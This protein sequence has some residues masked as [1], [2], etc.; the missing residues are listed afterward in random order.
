LF[1]L[2]NFVHS[3]TLNLNLSCCRDI[4]KIRTGK[5]EIS[6]SPADI[7]WSSYTIS[8]GDSSYCGW[9]VNGWYW[10]QCRFW[11]CW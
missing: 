6:G 5:E 9:A 3:V 4:S 1:A 7:Q 10:D 8:L 2:I 11:Y